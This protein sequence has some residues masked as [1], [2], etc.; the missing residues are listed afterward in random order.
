MS[1]WN[2][3]SSKEQSRLDPKELDWNLAGLGVNVGSKRSPKLRQFLGDSDSDN[4]D[5][6]FTLDDASSSSDDEE[7]DFKETKPPPN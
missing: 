5:E 1:K 6:S 2:V 3:D 7:F 4:D